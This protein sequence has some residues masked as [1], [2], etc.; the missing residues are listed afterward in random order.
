MMFSACTRCDVTEEKDILISIQLIQQENMNLNGDAFRSTITWPTKYHT[1]ES[2]YLEVTNS[3]FFFQIPLNNKENLPFS[4]RVAVDGDD[5]RFPIIGNTLPIRRSLDPSD[6]PDK[7]DE[8]AYQIIVEK[9][10]TCIVLTD[11]N[12]KSHRL[13]QSM[14]YWNVQCYDVTLT[15]EDKLYHARY[16]KI[17][18]I[19]DSEHCHDDN[20]SPDLPN[21]YIGG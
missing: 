18:W 21:I 8:S 3:G 9:M 12:I 6:Y 2:D 19:Y 16:E 14:K 5:I 1:D 13:L 11:E 4:Y 10:D 20:Y 7:I 15:R 17:E